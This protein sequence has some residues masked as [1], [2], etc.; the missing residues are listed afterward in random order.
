MNMQNQGKVV[1]GKANYRPATKQHAWPRTQVFQ[2]STLHNVC[3]NLLTADL[4]CTILCSIM[5][6]LFSLQIF[7]R[8]Q[9]YIHL[10]H[11]LFF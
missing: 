3:F 6:F 8:P 2:F 4:P 1:L 9:K 5:Y 7:K 10:M 11:F